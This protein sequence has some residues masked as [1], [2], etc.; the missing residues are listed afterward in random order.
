MRT[1]WRREGRNCLSGGTSN[2][3]SVCGGLP[4]SVVLP[5][6][7][8]PECRGREGEGWGRGWGRGQTHTDI[9]R[10]REGGGDERKR[11]RERGGGGLL[12]R[13]KKTY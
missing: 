7:R 4:V 13:E 11:E 9:L 12:L 10:E 3:L 1:R 6:Q 5:A 8:H 2:S